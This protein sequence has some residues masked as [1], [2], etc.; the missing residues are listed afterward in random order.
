MSWATSEAVSVLTFLLPGFVGAAVFYALTS[1]PRPGEFDRVVQALVFTTVAQ[2]IT[3]AARWIGG[4]RWPGYE[5]PAGLELSVSVLGAVGIALL[6]AA[7]SNHDT[8]HRLLRRISVTRETAYPSEW[9]SAFAENSGRYI[10]LHLRDGRRL[11]GWPMEWPGS[12]AAGHFRIGEAHWLDDGQDGDAMMGT[13]EG[14]IPVVAVGDD[15][16]E[17]DAMMETVE[18]LIPVAAVGMV[19]FLRESEPESAGP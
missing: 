13:V 12:A 7:V 17:G 19:Q 8:A 16:Q 6:A 2:A 5:W 3:A 9:Y 1:H 4:W 11:Y 18:V 10:V 15:G 14:L